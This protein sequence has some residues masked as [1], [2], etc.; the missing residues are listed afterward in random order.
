MS[1]RKRL[2]NPLAAMDGARIPGGCDSCDAVQVVKAGQL[3]Y[4]G[5]SVPGPGLNTI[6]VYH[7]DACPEQAARVAAGAAFTRGP[8]SGKGWKS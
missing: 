3:S 4:G 7:D 6:D 5:V 1:N 8:E 2:H